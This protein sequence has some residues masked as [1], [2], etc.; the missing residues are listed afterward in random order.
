MK[1]KCP[2]LFYFI[3][4]CFCFILVTQIVPFIIIAL[5]FSCLPLDVCERYQL[6]FKWSIHAIGAFCFHI[7]RYLIL[8]CTV[9]AQFHVNN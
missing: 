4:C 8:L 7:F 9:F 1:H 5:P 3:C 6:L 2:R